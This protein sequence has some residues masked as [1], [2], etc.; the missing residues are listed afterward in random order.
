MI[1]LKKLNESIDETL[2]EPHLLPVYEYVLMQNIGSNDFEKF[3]YMYI[4]NNGKNLEEF[5]DKLEPSNLC[6]F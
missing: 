1:T 6:G 4:Q 3:R 2:F 5:N